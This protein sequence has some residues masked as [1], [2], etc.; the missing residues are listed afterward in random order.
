MGFLIKGKCLVTTRKYSATTSSHVRG[1]YCALYKAG[2]D[3]IKC[4]KVD[5]VGSLCE[6]K[7]NIQGLIDT[8][9]EFAAKS[10]RARKNG[11]YCRGESKKYLQYARD[12]IALFR[13]KFKLPSK[14][15][16]ALYEGVLAWLHGLS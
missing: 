11:D 5:G 2:I 8:A 14:I 3:V 15:K 6:H 13:I 10:R 1:L 9:Y 12:Y 16:K 7:T 4:E